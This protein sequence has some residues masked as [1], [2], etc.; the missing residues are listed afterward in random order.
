MRLFCKMPVCRQCGVYFK[1]APEWEKRW[2][3]LCLTHRRPLIEEYARKQ[4][5][6]AWAESKWK[7]LEEQMK[8]E[9]DEKQRA[10]AN[11]SQASLASLA[12]MQK[13]NMYNPYAPFGNPLGGGYP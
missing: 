13:N 6:L 1:A 7:Q 12:G 10:S 9:N 4:L 2:G 8:K 3:D 5:V 11:L